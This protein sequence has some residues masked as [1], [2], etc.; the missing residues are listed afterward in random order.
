MSENDW[1]GEPESVP[2]PRSAV[3]TFMYFQSAPL[4][5]LLENTR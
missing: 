4:R 3:R 2:A 5:L 1:E